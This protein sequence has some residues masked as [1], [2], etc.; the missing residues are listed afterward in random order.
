MSSQTPPAGPAGD[1]L[2]AYGDGAAAAGYGTVTPSIISPDT[3]RLIDFATAAFGAQELARVPG[4]DGRIGHAEIASVTL[5]KHS[6]MSKRLWTQP[7]AGTGPERAQGQPAAVAVRPGRP[8][9]DGAGDRR[10]GGRGILLGRGRQPAW[11]AG[12]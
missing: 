6:A 11:R 9:P 10:S 1:S 4:P 5:P 3:A 2:Q 12:L 7:C 8:D